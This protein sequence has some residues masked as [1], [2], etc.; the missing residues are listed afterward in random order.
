MKI[1]HNLDSKNGLE[2]SDIVE[3]SHVFLATKS[4]FE[5]ED[6]AVTH[7]RP[8]KRKIT[9]SGMDNE[10]E[11][12]EDTNE[13]ADLS[14]VIVI[15]D[16]PRKIKKERADKKNKKHKKRKIDKSS[17]NSS[18]PL[19]SI[20][21]F[22]EPETEQS[23]SIDNANSKK[24]ASNDQHAGQDN[25]LNGSAPPS[26]E[27]ARQAAL[28]DTITRSRTRSDSSGHGIYEALVAGMLA[29]PS[30][31]SPMSSI[32]DY[33]QSLVDIGRSAIAA[34]ILPNTQKPIRDKAFKAQ[35]PALAPKRVSSVHKGSPIPPPVRKFSSTRTL[36]T[37]KE[38]GVERRTSKKKKGADTKE[39][40]RTKP[41]TK[42]EPGTEGS[43]QS[44]TL[45]QTITALKE[46]A[47]ASV[48]EGVF[49]HADPFTSTKK[50]LPPAK[51]TL[52]IAASFP[53]SINS[54]TL[55]VTPTKSKSKSHR[56]RRIQGEAE[57]WEKSSGRVRARVDTDGSADDEE[58]E[59]SEFPSHLF[60]YL[61]PCQNANTCLDIAFSSTYLQARPL[62]ISI[63]GTKFQILNIVSGTDQELPIS[64]DKD[65]IKIC[66]VAKGRVKV[67][68][69]KTNF[70]IGEGG[71]WR[72]HG[73][74][75]CVVANQLS[76]QGTACVH[77]CTVKG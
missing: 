19:S 18:Q 62:G 8:K 68:L 30:P 75:K 32:A 21:A 57:D 77:I 7:V 52:P 49:S 65:T 59:E 41:N 29:Q 60:N 58:M 10:N 31:P 13:T 9:K 55:D 33:P 37:A 47:S 53:N 3:P 43:Q 34:P 56:Q 12:E 1:L 40:S 73:G 17:P 54:S 76:S 14:K 46:T 69:G 22:E 51:T 4:K 26:P 74:E 5:D 11:S 48:I 44:A 42:P 16:A 72:V 61:L 27:K 63:S 38:N 70:S 50:I 25:S 71:V 23:V 67:S 35:A 28:L 24:I 2:V 39:V 36:P 6:Q 64:T 45:S 20:P 66:S 15:E